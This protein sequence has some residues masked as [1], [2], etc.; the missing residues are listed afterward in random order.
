MSDGFNIL[1]IAKKAHDFFLLYAAGYLFQICRVGGRCFLLKLAS[2]LRDRLGIFKMG[3]GLAG[4]WRGISINGDT[5][6][7]YVKIRKYSYMLW[8]S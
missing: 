1:D 7:H 6:C 3:R 5:T 8:L 2:Y 4:Y